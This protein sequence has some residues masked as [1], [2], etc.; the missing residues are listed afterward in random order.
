MIYKNFW[1]FKKLK[2]IAAATRKSR[3]RFFQKEIQVVHLFP[4]QIIGKFSGRGK[5]K[6]IFYLYAHNSRNQRA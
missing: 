4:K 6:Q 3:T 1:H 5:A 2:R